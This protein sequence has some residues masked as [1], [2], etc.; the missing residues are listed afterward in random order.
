MEYLK[1]FVEKMLIYLI[2]PKFYVRQDTYKFVH[3]FYFYY[4]CLLL[5]THLAFTIGREKRF[6]PLSTSTSLL[7]S[8]PGFLRILLPKIPRT[9]QCMSYEEF[10]GWHFKSSVVLEYYDGWQN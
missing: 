5:G 3:H 6:W 2:M 1:E 7:E 9:V 4:Y 8:G 10:A